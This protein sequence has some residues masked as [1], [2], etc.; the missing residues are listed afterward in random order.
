M[1]RKEIK[2]V[3]ID[4]DLNMFYGFNHTVLKCGKILNGLH[5]WYSKKYGRCSI[6]LVVF[7]DFGEPALKR[8]RPC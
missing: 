3:R 7:V 2:S 4:K 5:I 1:H 8:Q 6:I